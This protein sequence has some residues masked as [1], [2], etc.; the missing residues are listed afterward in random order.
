MHLILQ[1]TI[2]NQIS[3]GVIF[4]LFMLLQYGKIL[5]YKWILL[6]CLFVG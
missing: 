6:L 1:K 4:C 3:V 5:L 2:E